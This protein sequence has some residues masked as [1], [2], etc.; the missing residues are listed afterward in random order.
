MERENGIV[1][2]LCGGRSSTHQP[3]VGQAFE[4]VAKK[5]WSPPAR[6][7]RIAIHPIAP[8][9]GEEELKVKTRKSST[10]KIAKRTMKKATM[11]TATVMRP[12]LYHH[13]GMLRILISLIS[14]SEQRRSGRWRGTTC[15]TNWFSIWSTAGSAHLI[16]YI[17]S[18]L[19]SSEF[20]FYSSKRMEP[21]S[22]GNDLG[23]KR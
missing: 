20:C 14:G 10:M 3:I 9:D 21:W 4:H 16:L 2:V 15:F 11:Q 17:T 13:K 7:N 1:G 23:A 5:V 22:Q 19:T 8:D 6:P 18:F 12:V